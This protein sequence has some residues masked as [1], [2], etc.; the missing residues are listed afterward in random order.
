MDIDRLLY[1]H[2]N[3][4]VNKT[5]VSVPG[6]IK[7]QP[8][9]YSKQFLRKTFQNSKRHFYSDLRLYQRNFSELISLKIILLM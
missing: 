6:L 3:A 5:L 1:K 9:R 7:I 4:C 8:K 2:W